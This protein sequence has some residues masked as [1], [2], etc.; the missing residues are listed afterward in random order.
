LPY[1]GSEFLLLTFCGIRDGLI[2]NFPCYC[3]SFPSL[4]VL[5]RTYVGSKLCILFYFG[6]FQVHALNVRCLF[7]VVFPVSDD[8]L[9]VLKHTRLC[10]KGLFLLYESDC[11]NVT[12]GKCAP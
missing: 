10:I 8:F 3:S 4:H 2:K 9:F 6:L 11:K 12:Q 5:A 7:I 1:A